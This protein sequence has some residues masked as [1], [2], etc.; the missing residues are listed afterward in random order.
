M[1]GMGSSPEF[2]VLMFHLVAIVFGCCQE[3]PDLSFLRATRGKSVGG[4]AATRT[5]EGGYLS[6][7]TRFRRLGNLPRPKPWLPC[8]FTSIDD[9]RL[10]DLLR[11]IHP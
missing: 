4:S 10:D 1:A 8:V 6:P 7:G 5:R 2:S 11:R 3:R 9:P